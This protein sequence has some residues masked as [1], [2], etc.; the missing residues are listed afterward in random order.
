MTG[1]GEDYAHLCFVA[2]EHPGDLA[3]RNALYVLQVERLPLPLGEAG[4]RPP[5]QLAGLPPLGILRGE[6]I[7]PRVC[8]GCRNSGSAR[9]SSR[10]SRHRSARRAVPVPARSVPADRAP[11]P[12]L[13]LRTAAGS[14][15]SGTSGREA[16]RYLG[17]S[18]TPS[19]AHK[20]KRRRETQHT[21]AIFHIFSPER[22]RNGA[23]IR[24][25]HPRPFRPVRPAGYP[26]TRA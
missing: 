11:H 4:H 8:G 6:A 16:A 24:P 19:F 17:R 12:P 21:P 13:R 22:T 5:H 23:G 2:A 15:H 26:F 7:R 20:T 9:R 10:K 25:R 18:P 14:A 3:G 1:A